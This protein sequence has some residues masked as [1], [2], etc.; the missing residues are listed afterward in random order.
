LVAEQETVFVLVMGMVGAM[1]GAARFHLVDFLSLAK[2]IQF[3]MQ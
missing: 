3:M 2:P 1:G